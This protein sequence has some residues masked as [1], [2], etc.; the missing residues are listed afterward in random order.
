MVTGRVG[1]LVAVVIDADNPA[2]H[3][4]QARG[5]V[6]EAVSKQRA[7]GRL[8]AL[9][10]GAPDAARH[11][12]AWVTALSGAGVAAGDIEARI[13]ANGPDAADD[14]LVAMVAA[15]GGCASGAADLR[16]IALTDDLGLLRRIRGLVCEVDVL[17]FP[18]NLE[19][20]C[21]SDGASAALP[22][23]VS[24]GAVEFDR[25]CRVVREL[26]VKKWLG[27]AGYS[28]EFVRDTVASAALPDLRAKG[29]FGGIGGHRVRYLMRQ[30]V[31]DAM[32][33]FGVLVPCAGARRRYGLHADALG[34]L[35]SVEP[36]VGVA[37]IGIVG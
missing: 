34:W 35:Q 20:C 21:A 1:A 8:K 16:A 22:P 24:C 14:A 19:A 23:S 12:G 17:D 26:G 32:V 3:G 2:G 28:L 33:A 30:E 15:L 27:R 29:G 6:I 25:M 7:G 13:V 18:V 31:V 11:V 10:A 36:G 37:R 5:R 9:V 4:A